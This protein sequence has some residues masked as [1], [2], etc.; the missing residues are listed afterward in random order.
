[1]VFKNG[2]HAASSVCGANW[3]VPAGTI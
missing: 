1:M 3:I 2:L